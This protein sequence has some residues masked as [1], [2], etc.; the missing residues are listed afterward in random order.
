M[1][2]LQ[3]DRT[4]LPLE[5][6]KLPLEPLHLG[7]PTGASKMVSKA[8]STIGCFQNGLLVYGTLGRKPCTYLAPKQTLSPN[9]PNR[10]YI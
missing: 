4:K 8:W 1:Q 6:T 2:Y 9:R 3:T 10:D 5:P 7:V